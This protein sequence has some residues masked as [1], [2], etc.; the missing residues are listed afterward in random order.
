MPIIP[1]L[2]KL[3]WE[4]CEFEASLSYIVRH[5]LKKT[6]IHRY[7]YIYICI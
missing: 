1:V 7:I 2:R 6:Q 3:R 4:D 5:C